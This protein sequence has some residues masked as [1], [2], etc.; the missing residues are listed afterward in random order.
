MATRGGQAARRDKPSGLPF[1]RF[2]DIAAAAGPRAPVIYG[3]ADRNEYIIEAIGCG[4]AFGWLDIFVLCGTRLSGAPAGATN[5]L[6][7]NNRDGTFT[8]VTERAGLVKT[9]WAYGVTVGDYNNDGFEDLFITCFRQNVL[10]RNNLDG[11]LDVLKTHFSGDTPA[12]YLNRGKSGFLD[13]TLRSSLGVQTRFV[14]WVAAIVDLDNDGYPDLFWLVA[15]TPRSNGSC[16]SIRTGRRGC[17][18]ATWGTANSSNSRTRR[19][20]PSWRPIAAAG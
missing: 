14:S 10:Y 3:D 2:T 12:L 19:G 17:C 6:Y 7:K 16:R 13:A 8:D 20:R 9:G 5:R 18:F 11:N 15:S 4:V 1:A